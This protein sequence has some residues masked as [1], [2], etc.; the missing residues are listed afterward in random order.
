[1]TITIMR[2]LLPLL[3]LLACQACSTLTWA[4]YPL[5]D[6]GRVANSASNIYWIDAHRV[7]FQG[8]FWN[9]D[10]SLNAPDGQQRNSETLYEWDIAAGRLKEH[11]DIGG[12]LCYANG[13]VRYWRRVDAESQSSEAE[14]IAGELG[15]QVKVGS[16]YVS[17]DRETCKLRNEAALPDWTHGKAVVR[18][19]PEFGFLVSGEEKDDRNT[20]VMYHPR[21]ERDGILMP[22]KRREFHTVTYFG[23]KAAYFLRADYFV[24]VAGH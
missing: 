8:H 14:W 11:G 12:G 23:F 9:A 13:Y 22:F 17:V 10:G 5:R 6:S 1:M 3:A 18:L 19:T 4:E 2:L 21:G 7:L 24:V 15:R 20:P 16:Q